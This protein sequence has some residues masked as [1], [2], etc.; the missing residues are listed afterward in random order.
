MSIFAKALLYLGLYV[1]LHFGYE[2]TGWEVLRPV[3]GGS[4]SIF[5]HL[6]MGFFAYFFTTLI[7]FGVIRK[8]PTLRRGFWPSRILATWS[9]PW[10]IVT[11][12]YLAPAVFRKPLPL[13]GELSWA[14]LVTFI[15]GIAGGVLERGLEDEWLS[16][17]VR[18]TL[19]LLFGISVFFFVWFTYR[20]PWV[21][22][23]EVPTP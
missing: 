19:L 14:I 10:I 11:V 15:S 17:G 2:A 8:R 5:E 23:F 6:K 13:W 16:P 3:F 1:F 4:E 20:M 18:G 9:I 22:L 7:E 12:W 21:D